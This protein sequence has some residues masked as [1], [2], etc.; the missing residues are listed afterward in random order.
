MAA[1][2]QWVHGNFAWK[3]TDLSTISKADFSPPVFG[4]TF[5]DK[6]ECR[7]SLVCK[8]LCA[9]RCDMPT[10]VFTTPRQGVKHL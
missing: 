1:T 3:Q 4:G 8:V 6:P 2:E 10:E 5:V 9:V 7:Q